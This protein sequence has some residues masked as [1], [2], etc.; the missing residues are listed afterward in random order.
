[1]WLS[2]L[3]PNLLILRQ[4]NWEPDH[5]N[6]LFFLT[7]HDTYLHAGDAVF[8]TLWEMSVPRW[9]IK[10]YSMIQ[11]EQKSM[12][13]LPIIN[14][15]T[16]DKI[17]KGTMCTVHGIQVKGL[18]GE[19]DNLP[20]IDPATSRWMC[21]EIPICLLSSCKQNSISISREETK[22]TCFTSKN[23]GKKFH[24]ISLKM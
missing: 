14:T 22:V 11:E 8:V 1:M 16:W 19:E 12:H 20:A 5:F 15:F 18:I 2:T 23:T 4:V 10:T 13:A 21:P 24:C 3:S 17:V 6:V 7:R 9:Q